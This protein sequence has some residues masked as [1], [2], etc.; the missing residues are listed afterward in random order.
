MIL[1]VFQAGQEQSRWHHRTPL[2]S[3]PPR[4]SA[5][6]RLILEEDGV[7]PITLLGR[8]QVEFS[9]DGERLSVN[10]LLNSLTPGHAASTHH[11]EAQANL[12]IPLPREAI[13]RLQFKPGQPGAWELRLKNVQIDFAPPR[14]L[15]VAR[16]SSELSRALAAPELPAHALTANVRSHP[17]SGPS[18]TFHSMAG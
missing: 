18:T 8:L 16:Q 9:P 6:I 14:F 11:T 1:Q 15:N 4:N 12:S 17:R 5:R 3:E 10:V 13:H 2:A 7:R